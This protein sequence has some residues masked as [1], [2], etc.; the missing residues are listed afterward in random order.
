MHLQN[1]LQEKPAITA[2][3]FAAIQEFMRN[4][5]SRMMLPGLSSVVLM[6]GCASVSAPQIP[7][8]VPELQPGIMTGYLRKEVLPHSL[9]LL[10][11]PPAANSA[12]FTADEETYRTTRALRNTPRW[13]LATEDANLKFPQAAEAFSCALDVPITREATPHLYM[14]MHRSLTDGGLATY[15]A[16]N[17]YQRIRP[18]ATYNDATCTPDEEAFL[19]NDGSYPSG[20]STIGWTWALT[21]AEVA[22]ERSDAILAR[23]LAFGQSRVICGVHWQSDVTAGRIVGAGTVARLHGDPVYRAELEAAK[24]EVAVVRKKGIKPARD[25]QA[26]DAAL[27]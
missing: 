1:I 25:C 21:L 16:K 3:I 8:D 7:T 27:K 17:H 12:A 15:T 22:P 11:P 20:H 9:S 13:T 4:T 18:F 5:P 19:R 10:P 2:G 14:L 6:S 23:G 24:K 26:E